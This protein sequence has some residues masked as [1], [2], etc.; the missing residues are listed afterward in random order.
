MK[1][2]LVGFV[3]IFGY[4]VVYAAAVELSKDRIVEELAQA[5]RDQ[6]MEA[7]Q[8]RLDFGALRSFLKSDLK[9]KS[10]AVRGGSVK[11]PIGPEPDKVSELVDFY[12][13]PERIGLL[14]GLKDKIFPDADPQDFVWDVSFY[15][16]FAF[17]VTVGYPTKKGQQT[18]FSERMST[19][20][21][22]FKGHGWV[23]KAKE[24]HV[25]LFMVPIEQYDDAEIEKLLS[26]TF[27]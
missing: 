4:V 7:F 6:D 22:V 19:V 17:A 1:L 12:V 2:F 5:A 15:G 3:L 10:K 18:L 26:R 24:M 25:P 9:K 20:T 8:S 23:W 16:P 11:V 14:F 27:P 13:Q 21:F